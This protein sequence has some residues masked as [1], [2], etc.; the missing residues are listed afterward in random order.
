MTL[1]HTA[2]AASPD[3]ERELLLWLEQLPP[4]AV[5]AP[6]IHGRREGIVGFVPVNDNKVTRTKG[7]GSNALRR[8]RALL[9]EDRLRMPLVSPPSVHV[10]DGETVLIWRDVSPTPAQRAVL[11]RM[12]RRVCRIG[13]SS[14]LVLCRS[15]DAVP[16]PHWVPGGSGTELVLRC[17]SRGTLDEMQHRHRLVARLGTRQVDCRVSRC[18]IAV[19]TQHRS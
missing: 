16:E 11:G 3:A 10:G 14:S 17:P 13:H 7:G 5:S 18:R 9:P 1:R 2:T 8:Q 19:Q 12:L 6:P 4:P 15:V